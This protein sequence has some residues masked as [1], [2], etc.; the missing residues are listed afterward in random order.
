MRVLPLDSPRWK[1]LEHAYGSAADIPPMIRQL[2]DE[3]TDQETLD[4]VEDDFWNKAFHQCCCC[5][6]LWAAIPHFV[7]ALK[8]LSINRQ[9]NLLHCMSVWMEED[10]FDCRFN[11]E[12]LAPDHIQD[13]DVISMYI[14][15]KPIAAEHVRGLLRRPELFQGDDE[16]CQILAM[17]NVVAAA[18]GLSFGGLYPRC[19]SVEWLKFDCSKCDAKDIE[20]EAICDE[21]GKFSDPFFQVVE[22]KVPVR[23]LPRGDIPDWNGDFSCNP[24]TWILGMVEGTENEAA[25]NRM[26]AIFGDVTCPKCNATF[27]LYSVL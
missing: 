4:E 22:T 26:R 18:Q 27:E 17:L 24:K 5:S 11:P 20:V 21:N 10:W 1:Q 12:S 9:L 7:N 3:A 23:P 13:L 2:I 6:A 8:R 15:S 14:E 25:M 19:E 16:V